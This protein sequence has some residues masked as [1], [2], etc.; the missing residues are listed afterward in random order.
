MF[1]TDE[2]LHKV[3]RTVKLN[4]S[5]FKTKQCALLCSVLLCI[6]VVKEI[7]RRLLM[8]SFFPAVE[9]YINFFRTAWESIRSRSLSAAFSS[10]KAGSK[11]CSL[12][13]L[14]RTSQEAF[15]LAPNNH[16]QILC[17][18]ALLSLPKKVIV[19]HKTSFGVLGSFKIQHSTLSLLLFLL[20]W[21]QGLYAVKT[22]FV[23]CKQPV[24]A[25]NSLC[26]SDLICW[27]HNLSCNPT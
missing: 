18:A 7:V 4:S 14:H 23:L 8:Y 5:F 21:L 16:R 27:W 10:L 24:F 17:H 3:F 22:T 6:L 20:I 12:K 9:N 2:E 26:Y 15:N 13:Q 25:S 11:I 1:Q 19:I